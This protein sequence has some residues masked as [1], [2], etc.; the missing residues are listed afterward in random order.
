[1]RSTAKSMAAVVLLKGAPA[2]VVSQKAVSYRLKTQR[3]T[4]TLTHSHFTTHTLPHH[5]LP[6]THASA[7]K[8]KKSCSLTSCRCLRYPPCS[9]RVKAVSDLR[10]FGVIPTVLQMSHLFFSPPLR[11]S[12]PSCAEVLERVAIY[13]LQVIWRG[14]TLLCKL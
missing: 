1:M 5:T 13:I 8:V 4:Y 2:S 7:H 10:R 3:L 9:P 11:R 6:H 14:A 12:F